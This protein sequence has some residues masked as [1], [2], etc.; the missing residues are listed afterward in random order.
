MSH[1]TQAEAR[2]LVE[3]VRWRAGYVVELRERIEK[4]GHTAD[5]LYPA[6][7]AAAEAMHGLWVHLHYRAT[8][9]SRPPE[10]EGSEGGEGAAGTN[11]GGS[12]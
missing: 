11:V 2:V 7:R 10:S 1:V 3:A 8:G 9:M 6:V 4:S 12:P 5:P